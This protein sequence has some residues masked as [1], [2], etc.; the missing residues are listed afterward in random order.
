MKLVYAAGFS[1]LGLLPSVS[2]ATCVER[3]SATLFNGYV[4]GSSNNGGLIASTISADVRVTQYDK[5]FAH[6]FNVG[7]ERHSTIELLRFDGLSNATDDNA[8]SV[9]S[10]E[11]TADASTNAELRRT[12]KTVN[13]LTRFGY[14]SVLRRYERFKPFG[15]IVSDSNEQLNL[16]AL[17]R[18]AFGIRYQAINSENQH[19]YMSLGLGEQKLET[20]QRELQE[21]FLFAQ[22][23]Y[24]I[25]FSER[26]SWTL[27]YQLS[28]GEKFNH[29]ELNLA[30]NF[31][32]SDNAAIVFSSSTR[33][34]G[35]ALELPEYIHG[36]SETRSAI[37]IVF[38]ARV[39]H[40]RLTRRTTD[41]ATHN[42][43]ATYLGKSSAEDADL[44]AAVADTATEETDQSNTH[45]LEQ[46]QL[47]EKCAERKSQ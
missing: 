20:E 37:G 33:K 18:Y 46:A 10:E 5:V 13:G 14:Q 15:F 47:T 4:S 27:N 30:L 11:T 41:N 17:D 42:N 23:H 2:G 28:D 32:F 34:Y 45:S 22:F 19:L 38:K 9:E 26:S 43:E 39:P 21:S 16:D 6:N 24:A 36:R 7:M 3:N 31:W 25:D 44:V 1:L 35:S 29:T 12:V 40:G 8:E